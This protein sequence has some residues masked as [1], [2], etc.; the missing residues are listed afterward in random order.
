MT[1]FARR[2]ALVVALVLIALHPL[3]A[4][5]LQAAPLVLVAELLVALCGV[6]TLW[7]AIVAD[8][9]V[10]LAVVFNALRLLRG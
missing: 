5:L 10:S 9:G 7:M 6:A 8:M 1:P 4:E 2:L 3:N